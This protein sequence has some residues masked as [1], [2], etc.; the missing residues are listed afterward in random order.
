[1]IPA[2]RINPGVKNNLLKLLPDRQ[3]TQADPLDFTNRINIGQPISEN[4][5]FLRIDHN[6]SA[7]D[8]VFARLARQRV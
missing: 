7:K 2:T 6:I 4:A 1:M 5:V 3:F 8:R